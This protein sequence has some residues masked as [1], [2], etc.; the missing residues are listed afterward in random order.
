M[1]IILIFIYWRKDRK[2][3]E[4]SKP[5]KVYS[6]EEKKSFSVEKL[7]LNLESFKQDELISAD[8]SQ[9]YFESLIHNEDT[10]HKNLKKL[11]ENEQPLKV[12]MI[13]EKP[14]VAKSIAKALA[15]KK[16][17]PSRDNDEGT[18]IWTYS[19]IKKNWHHINKI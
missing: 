6:K 4:K 12:L 13:A 11:T 16:A 3:D 10:I 1:N 5:N 15:N 18:T 2:Y 14:S 8:K 19:I 9:K 7:S 17:I